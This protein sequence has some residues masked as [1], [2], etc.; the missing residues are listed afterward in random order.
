MRAVPKALCCALVLAGASAVVGCSTDDSI[1]SNVPGINTGTLVQNWSIQ[2]QRDTN[3]C[4]QYNAERMRVVV[5]DDAGS[6]S[7]TEFAPCVAFEIRLELR[8]RRYTGNAT[9]LDANGN[10]VSKT[11]AIPAFAIQDELSLTQNLDFGAMDMRP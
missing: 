5:F 8:T 6:V 9:F 4:V 10:P 3:K 11:M 1:I 7:A 2:G